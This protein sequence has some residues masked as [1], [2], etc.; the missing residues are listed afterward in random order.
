MGKTQETAAER[1]TRI[2]VCVGLPVLFALLG[3]LGMYLTKG[4]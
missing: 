4:G 3:L 2:A 1:L